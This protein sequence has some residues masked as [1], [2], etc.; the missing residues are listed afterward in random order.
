MFSRKSSRASSECSNEGGENSHGQS[1]AHEKDYDRTKTRTPEAE[2]EKFDDAYKFTADHPLGKILL[3]LAQDQV[4]LARVTNLKSMSTNIEELCEGFQEGL[5]LERTEHMHDAEYV[6][7]QVEEHI[8]HKE[9]NSHKFSS[10]IAAPPSFSQVDVLHNSAKL[11]EAQRVFPRQG[12]FNGYS[13][14]GG[15]SVTEFLT[16]LNEAQSKCNLSEEEFI[17]RM[18]YSS[19]GMA[20]DLIME[21]RNNGE[22]ADT[23]YHNLLLNF[24]K[25]LSPDDAKIQLS[26]FKVHKNSN[27]AHAQSKIMTLAGRAADSY[28]AGESRKAYFNLEAIAALLKSLPPASSQIVSNLNHTLTARLGRA[29]TFTELSKALN[30]YRVSIDKDIRQSGYDGQKKRPM[31]PQRMNQ[32]MYLG[33]TKPRYSAYSISTGVNGTGSN[34]VSDNTNK[35]NRPSSYGSQLNTTSG[36]F[37]SR[38]TYNNY[39]RSR[40]P[41]RGRGQRFGAN[42]RFGY[43]ANFNTGGR[44]YIAKCSLCGIPNHRPQECKNMRDDKGKIINMMPIPGTCN[45]CPLYIQ[46]RLHHQ[47]WICPY[48][49]GG[50][51]EKKGNGPANNR[52]RPQKKN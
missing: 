43:R 52:T 9:L 20:H 21:W 5:S 1:C 28:P 40:A 19:T 49:P 13:R 50:P 32:K 16:M 46:P 12:K 25:R 38:P 34:N 24:D 17:S 39:N 29:C 51:L 30:A 2:I 48:R 18:L 41:N 11:V 7:S 3:K 8:I 15:M 27:L 35:P 6:A 22:N 14:D 26:S 37:V 31:P 10:T 47:E 4:N 44:N 45:K 36:R 33:P 42:R 23:I